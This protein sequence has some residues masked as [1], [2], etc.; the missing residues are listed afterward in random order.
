MPAA[1]RQRLR[2]G[3]DRRIRASRDFARLKADGRR[4]PLG[5]MVVN[6]QPGKPGSVSKLGVITSRR[7]GGA[8]A[9]NRARRLMREVFRRNQSLLPGPTELVLI[10]R[11]SIAPFS[12]AEVER[13]FLH[14]L[15]R[16]QLSVAEP[17]SAKP[18]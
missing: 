12:Y 5:C 9:R 6:W 8:V 17:L 7:V 2:L 15:R 14:A 11:P 1:P 13:D 3:R 4:L 18:I 16:A 10:A